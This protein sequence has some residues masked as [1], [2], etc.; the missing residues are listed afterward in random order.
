MNDLFVGA[1][2]L[3]NVSTIVFGATLGGLFG[4][5]FKVRMRNLV[6]DA[7]GLITL[8]VGLMVQILTL[9]V[10]VSHFQQVMKPS[11]HNSQALSMH[12]HLA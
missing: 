11:P 4:S 7:L 10:Q 5:R 8:L 2:T 12:F 1:G 3:I 6:T 9:Q